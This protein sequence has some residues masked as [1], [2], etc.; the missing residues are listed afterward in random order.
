MTRVSSVQLGALALAH[1]ETLA[2][3]QRRCPRVRLAAGEQVSYAL[4]V[5]LGH[6]ALLPP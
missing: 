4:L 3:A 5:P 1:L 2:T 6:L